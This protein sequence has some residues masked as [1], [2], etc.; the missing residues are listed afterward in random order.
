MNKINFE[1]ACG[2]SS[3]LGLILSIIGLFKINMCST[4]IIF[5]IIIIIFVFVCTLSIWQY[6]KIKKYSDCENQ[7]REISNNLIANKENIINQNIS[8]IILQLVRVCT[9]ISNAFEIVKKN[10]IGVCIK[11]VNSENDNLYVKTLCRDINS[12]NNREDF[13]K[14]KNLDYLTQNTDF[15]HIMNLMK[16]KVEYKYLFY[17]QNNLDNTYQYNNTHLKE[18]NIPPSIFAYFQRKK[19]WPLPYKSTI[20]VPLLKENNLN[21][22]LCIDSPDSKC[23]IKGK[24]VA[25][26]QQI[27]LILQDLIN[28]ICVNHLQIK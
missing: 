28:F 19:K 23:F 21:G 3:V 15:T 10:K 1:T 6:D 25:I 20:V 26:V 24:D 8:D 12:Y 13:D 4:T 17:C 7:I 2:F 9:N 16:E 27:A 14:L 5:I 22:F 18:I 11:Y